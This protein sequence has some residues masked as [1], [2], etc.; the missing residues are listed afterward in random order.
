ME[1]I[2]YGKGGKVFKTLVKCLGMELHLGKLMLSSR[3]YAS[4]Y[5]S[6]HSQY[7]NQDNHT[8]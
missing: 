5:H 7:W 8:V 6:C 1:I 3:S 2:N 4:Q